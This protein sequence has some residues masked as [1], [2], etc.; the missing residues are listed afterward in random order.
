MNCEATLKNED[1]MNGQTKFMFVIHIMP[2][3]LHSTN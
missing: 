1:V 3:E 2:I